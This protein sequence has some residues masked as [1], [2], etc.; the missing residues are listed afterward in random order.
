[1]RLSVIIPTHNEQA[2]IAAAVASAQEGGAAEVI[3]ADGGSTDRTCQ[4]ARSV[5]AE[6]V[7]GANGRGPQQNAGAAA[8]TGDVVLFLHADCRLQPAASDA[9]AFALGVWPDCEAGGF[10]Q[11]YRPTGGGLARRLHDAVA[12]SVMAEANAVRGWWG[13]LYGDQAI[14]VRRDAFDRVGGFPDWPL[15]EDVELS[16]RLGLGRGT[17]ILRQPSVLVHERKFSGL[18]LYRQAWRNRRLRRAFR[19]GVPVE[20]LARRYRASHE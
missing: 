11:R 5:G 7:T 15:F 16:R 10:R 3:V 1:M 2:A 9:I 13:T 20:E 14:W 17:P 19:D 18:A 8:A 12:L 4:I 6:V